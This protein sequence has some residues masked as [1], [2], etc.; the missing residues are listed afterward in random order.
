MNIFI[1]ALGAEE[2]VSYYFDKHVVKMITEHTQLLSTANRLSGLDEG[3]KL[4]HKNHPCAIWVRESLSNWKWLKNLNEKLHNEYQYRYGKD[5]F[6]AAYVTMLTLSEP[7]IPDIG[8]TP[9]K[10]A[11]PASYRED[12]VVESYRNYYMGVEKEHLRSWKK[13]NKP[14]WFEL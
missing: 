9:F 14:Y 7:D 13:R 4:T 5:K 3:Y 10:A 6:H 2:N 11:M 12:C 1:L 8:P